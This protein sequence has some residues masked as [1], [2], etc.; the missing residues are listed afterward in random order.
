MTALQESGVDQSEIDAVVK[1]LKPDKAEELLEGIEAEPP[2][3]S[4]FEIEFGAGDRI[5]KAN[6]PIIGFH[7]LERLLP[8]LVQWVMAIYKKDT[9]S[10]LE[11]SDPVAVGLG[12]IEHI[13]SLPSN[14]RLKLSVFEEFEALF[15]VKKEFL[16]IC[17]PG[18]L[19]DA[20]GK[21]V[22][23]NKSFFDL[24]WARVPLLLKQMIY[25]QIINAIETLEKLNLNS[26]A[27][28]RSMIKE[29]SP[30]SS[31]LNGGQSNTGTDSSQG[32]QG[33]KRGKVLAA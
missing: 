18:Q 31:H 8:K 28:M 21:V 24:A 3:K 14:A 30:Q 1:A 23:T 26:M 19:F 29:S 27:Y 2:L 13:M 15:G 20:V 7:D 4:D 6:I 12:V 33:K 17:P 10:H 32:S 16:L 11:E 9:R 5:V 22:E 25:Y